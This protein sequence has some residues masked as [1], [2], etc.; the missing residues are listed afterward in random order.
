M[1]AHNILVSAHEAECTMHSRRCR[2]YDQYL[3]RLRDAYAAAVHEWKRCRMPCCPSCS[4]VDE[5]P[6]DAG[7]NGGNGTHAPAADEDQLDDALRLASPGRLERG[8]DRPPSRSEAAIGAR[9]AVACKEGGVQI[10]GVGARPCLRFACSA[11][12]HRWEAEPPPGF[13]H[14]PPQPPTAAL[15]RPSPPAR[16]MPV[17]PA[18]PLLPVAPELP[19]PRAPAWLSAAVLTHARALPSDA[20]GASTSQADASIPFGAI[21]VRL[22]G[23]PGLTLGGRPLERPLGKQPAKP[24]AAAKPTPYARA[25]KS[26]DEERRMLAM[27]LSMSAAEARG[28]MAAVE[29][30]HSN[31]SRASRD[32]Q[33]ATHGDGG[34]HSGSRGIGGGHATGS[35]ASSSIESGMT[36]AA[37]VQRDGSHRRPMVEVAAELAQAQRQAAAHF[38]AAST[39]QSSD[40]DAVAEGEAARCMIWGCKR[41]LLRCHG[42]KTDSSDLHGCAEVGHVL[43]GESTRG[44]SPNSPPLHSS[45]ADACILALSAQR[46]ASS[47]GG[48]CRISSVLKSSLSRS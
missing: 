28:A 11:C 42:V 15:P 27:A 30:H 46:L 33:H 22:Y 13:W 29:S 17:L 21:R 8:P 14:A 48:G 20:A 38:A 2:A 37:R 5:T 4:K 44:D 25:P 7:T 26:R 24:A 9:K 41:Q 40:D 12:K 10:A 45:P 6:F 31:A 23:C 18:M 43:C 39:W 35:S 19:P 34:S 1:I 32:A 36:L 47:D 16:I 3:S